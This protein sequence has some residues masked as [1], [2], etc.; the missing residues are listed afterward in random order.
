M[1]NVNS[2]KK[3]PKNPPKGGSKVQKEIKAKEL[4]SLE[5][6]FLLVS[7]GNDAHP[8]TDEDIKEIREKLI[9]LFE[10]N[11]VNCITFVTHHAVDVCVI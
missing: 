6:R 9:S 8:A 1:G 2:K 10:E 3:S 7:V 4:N 5:G 11:G